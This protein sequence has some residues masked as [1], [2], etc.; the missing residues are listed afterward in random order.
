MTLP[1][2][3]RPIHFAP[4]GLVEYRRQG[5]RLWAVAEGPFNVELAKNVTVECLQ[6]CRRMRTDGEFDRLCE[7][8]RSIL[9]PREAFQQL[10]T[11][12]REMFS[13]GLAPARTA[14]AFPPGLEGGLLLSPMAERIYASSGLTLG[15]F[16]SREDAL[17]WLDARRS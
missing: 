17:A 12:L 4:H 1:G 15:L 6:W 16:A 11:M 5:Q 9:A 7:F 3:L 2:A 8:R 13:E 14:Y 10:Q